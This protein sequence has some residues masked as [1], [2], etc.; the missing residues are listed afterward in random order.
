M[1]KRQPPIS[2]RHSTQST[3]ELPAFR[4]T[5]AFGPAPNIWPSLADN[6]MRAPLPSPVSA[7]P[8]SPGLILSLWSSAPWPHPHKELLSIFWPPVHQSP[9]ISAPTSLSSAHS[10]SPSLLKLVRSGH[11]ATLWSPQP[12]VRPPLWQKFLFAFLQTPVRLAPSSRGAIP[13]VTSLPPS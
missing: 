1:L 9:L 10:P 12:D 13:P 3:L 7:A 6:R 8:T 4:L 5:T 11:P 2:R